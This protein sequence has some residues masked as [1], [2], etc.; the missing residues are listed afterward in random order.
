MESATRANYLYLLVLCG[1][2]EDPWRLAL[3][4]DSSMPSI[5]KERY[6]DMQYQS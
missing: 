5:V 4:H 1:N 2:F 3:R 6:P